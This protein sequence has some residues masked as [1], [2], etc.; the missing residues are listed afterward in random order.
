MELPYAEEARFRELAGR[1]HGRGRSR[2]YS[3]RSSSARNVG[4]L[5]PKV[6]PSAA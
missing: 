1:A 5:F 6:H 3:M 4:S 2:F